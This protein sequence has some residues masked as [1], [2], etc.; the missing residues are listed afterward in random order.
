M[1]V[2]SSRFRRHPRQ[3]LLERLL[4]RCPLELV[5]VDEEAR[6]RADAELRRRDEPALHDLVLEL[7]VGEA[8]VEILLADAGEAGRLLQRA[9]PILRDGPAFLGLE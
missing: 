1:L 2:R 8:G 4:G 9:A 6:G 7:L 3:R 5:A